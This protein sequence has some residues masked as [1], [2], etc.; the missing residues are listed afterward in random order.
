MEKAA[1]QEERH[2]T[3]FHS[4]KTIYDH[5]SQLKWEN[6]EKLVDVL[7]SKTVAILLSDGI[8]F[9]SD[10]MGILEPRQAGVPPGCLGGSARRIKKAAK[11]PPL[12][13]F[14]RGLLYLF[15]L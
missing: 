11:K 7:T 4:K 10:V 13:G 12:G 6:T 9:G 3:R 2:T 5:L 1:A 8:T 14:F 15:L